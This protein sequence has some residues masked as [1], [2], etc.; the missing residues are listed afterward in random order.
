MLQL[1]ISIFAVCFLWHR[2]GGAAAVHDEDADLAI[3]PSTDTS[4]SQETL[5]DSNNEQAESQRP[6]DDIAA[7][8]DSSDKP[9]TT[10]FT[11]E[12]TT[13]L[14]YG[15]LATTES[16]LIGVRKLSRRQHANFLA[17][18][19]AGHRLPRELVDLVAD[20][21]YDVDLAI[22]QRKVDAY[23]DSFH[24]NTQDA[25]ISTPNE[26]EVQRQIVGA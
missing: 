25:R 15:I 17:L 14:L 10:T 12:I 4:P 7:T 21:L 20:E 5:S 13:G 8:Y 22:I 6:A 24:W 1:I 3:Q 23:E 16:W 2:L 9:L 11:T 19:I 26:R 18:K